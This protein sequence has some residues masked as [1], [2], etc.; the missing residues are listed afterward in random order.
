M[1]QDASKPIGLEAFGSDKVVVD[2]VGVTNTTSEKSVASAPCSEAC[3]TTSLPPVNPT[4]NEPAADLSEVPNPPA[5][6]P[7]E[8]TSESAAHA[9]VEHIADT[10]H[11]E[12]KAREEFI[13]TLPRDR[14]TTPPREGNPEIDTTPLRCTLDGFM[15]P[16]RTLDS[17]RAYVVQDLA[18]AAQT[19]IE[20]WLELYL[21]VNS[22][23]YRQWRAKIVKDSWFKDKD[24]QAALTAYSAT[25]DENER[26]APFIELLT[27][28]INM[29]RG[30]IHLGSGTSFPINDLSFLDHSKRYVKT[31]P[32]QGNAAAQR[33]PDIVLIRETA[34]PEEGRAQWADI[35]SW[36]ELK[37]TTSLTPLLKSV[38]VDRGMP[39]VIKGKG[40]RSKASAAAPVRQV[41]LG[42]VFSRLRAHHILVR[43]RARRPRAVLRLSKCQRRFLP[44]LTR[45]MNLLPRE[46]SDLEDPAK[47]QT[48]YWNISGRG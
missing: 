18:D 36:F 22:A 37:V 2:V 30:N 34:R 31:N 39:A 45:P 28:I 40:K 11:I 5:P 17:V 4:A 26:Y 23:T 1:D 16:D 43:R 33:K 44:A 21:G 46:P 9:L 24:I 47:R 8:A 14:H 10:L 29:A 15:E 35:L 6:I 27:R 25:T 12:G 48:I 38:R 20:D 42:F 19:T 3:G 7:S 32:E 41:R 13:R